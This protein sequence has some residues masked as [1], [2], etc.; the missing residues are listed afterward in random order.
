MEALLCRPAIRSVKEG[1]TQYECDLPDRDLDAEAREARAV[2]LAVA[3]RAD[4]ALPATGILKAGDAAVWDA[5]VTFAPHALDGCVWTM[6]GDGR[7]AIGFSDEGTSISVRVDPQQERRL[8]SLLADG[9]ELVPLEEWRARTP[10][11]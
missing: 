2:L 1:V 6:T 9:V 3:R 7:P 11:R 10:G 4:A 5:F 8:R